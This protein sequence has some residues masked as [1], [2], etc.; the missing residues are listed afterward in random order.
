MEPLHRLQGFEQ[1]KIVS[2]PRRLAILRL[3]MTRPATLSQLGQTLDEHPARVRHHLKILEKAG[4]IELVN[5]QVVRGF[6]EKYY[7]ARAQAFLLQEMLLPAGASAGTVVILGSHDLAL[8]AATRQFREKRE[9][10]FLL[11]PVGSLDGLIALR[12]GNAQ[13]AGCHLLDVASGEY[14]L[15]YVR[16]LFPDSDM[17]LFTLAHR[18]QGL[19]L[20]PGNPL[21]IHNLEHLAR[22]DIVMVNRNRGSGTRLWIDSEL[23]RLGLAPGELHGYRNEARTHTAVAQAVLRGQA[24]AG[25]GLQAAARQT[26][27]DFIPLFQERFD[28][29]MPL[30]LY[31]N[32][33]V[34]PLLEYLQGIEFRRLADALGGY[35][36][37]HTGEVVY[38]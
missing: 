36:T 29:V 35:E 17:C 4:L 32:T 5:T 1:Y 2:D 15:P 12:Q 22:E 9:L 34:G 25:V 37:Q 28:L 8:E 33:K 3:L 23:Q 14:N 13:I 24:N 27:L 16:H 11:V 19:L 18:Q 21:Q 30:E 26:G 20:A 31:Y 10:E 7:R 38:C 6:V